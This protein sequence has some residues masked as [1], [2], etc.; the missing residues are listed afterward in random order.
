MKVVDLVVLLVVVGAGA[1][2]V[3]VPV[4]ATPSIDSIPDDI[5]LALDTVV[6]I[7][8][9]D[10]NAPTYTYDDYTRSQSWQGSGCF[11]SSDGII[12]TAAHVVK[13]AEEFEVTL[14]DGR[15]LKATLAYCAKNIDVGFLKVEVKEPV[16]FLKI[17][18]KLPK[19]GSDV[20][21][22]GHP[23]GW[24]PGAAWTISRGIISGQGRSF[25]NFFGEKE[26]IQ[27]DAASYPGNS[28][29]PVIDAKGFIVG[30]LVGGFNGEE[31]ISIVTPGDIAWRHL[32][33]F[34]AMLEAL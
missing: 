6:H 7:R 3:F 23:Y 32:Q 9:T 28:G 33:V 5:P 4:G 34:R 15:V 29:G 31:C 25:D 16:P 19:L 24:E 17:N 30:V 13:D 26:M 22:I 8:A 18:R 27:A 14:R 11:V 1:I 10:V 2:A 12:M 21:V 20:W